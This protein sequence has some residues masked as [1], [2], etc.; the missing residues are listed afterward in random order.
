MSSV[1]SS[2]SGNAGAPIPPD[3]AVVGYVPA[4]PKGNSSDGD[5]DPAISPDTADEKG[6]ISA[7]GQEKETKATIHN[8]IATQQGQR[9]FFQE[10]QFGDT[11]A[12]IAPERTS[13]ITVGYTTDSLIGR[14][15]T[16]VGAVSATSGTSTSQGT[17]EGMK[18]KKTQLDQGISALVV[19]MAE[20]S[21]QAEIGSAKAAGAASSSSGQMDVAAACDSAVKTTQRFSQAGNFTG[22]Q[23]T[24]LDAHCNALNGLAGAHQAIGDSSSDVVSPEAQQ[25][26]VATIQTANTASIAAGGAPIASN[27]LIHSVSQPP[28]SANNLRWACAEMM[29]ATLQS[30]FTLAWSQYEQSQMARKFAGLQFQAGVQTGQA[31][32][33]QQMVTAYQN[34]ATAAVSACQ[35]VGSGICAGYAKRGGWSDTQLYTINSIFSSAGSCASDAV[36]AWGAI[37][38]A[39]LKMKEA[40]QQ[41]LQQLY[42]QSV[43]WL[44]SAAQGQGDL[45]QALIEL[46]QQISA[47]Q[48]QF[49][50]APSH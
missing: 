44:N 17:L 26:L 47:L 2:S 4:P 16:P 1:G 6:D 42:G 9:A 19:I 50:I 30:I 12:Q 29:I 25:S 21:S 39:P 46:R 48:K 27:E 32:Y 28:L 33:Q 20:P 35:T 49:S 24:V 5:G 7:R 13:V 8:E 43:S 23:K 31:Q 36:K 38:E 22:S 18:E 10:N 37:Q 45:I 34:I 41:A 40:V 11:V 14:A 15:Y 3:E